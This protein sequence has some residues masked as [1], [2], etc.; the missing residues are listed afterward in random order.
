MICTAATPTV[1]TSNLAHGLSV[2]QVANVSSVGAA[3]ACTANGI[4][5]A[6]VANQLVSVRTVLSTTTFELNHGATGTTPYACHAAST[7]ANPLLLNVSTMP[8]T[9]NTRVTN[10]AGQASFSWTDTMTTSGQNVV[11]AANGGITKSV[12]FYRLA[13]AAS[14]AEAGDDNAALA[15]N[16]VISKLKVWDAAGD[17]MVVCWTDAK[18]GTLVATHTTEVCHSYSWDANDQFATGGTVGNQAGTAATQAAWETAMGTKALTTGGTYGDL[19]GITYSALST[20]ISRLLS[21]A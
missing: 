21:G 1:C 13:T 9:G 5:A 8:T 17:S 11:T 14:V 6:A 18:T 16:D 12:T 19:A 15:N 4:G 10:S 3:N 7:A 20:G 2:G